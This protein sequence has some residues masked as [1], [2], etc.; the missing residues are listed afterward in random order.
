M[1]ET[2]LHAHPEMATVLKS[3]ANAGGNFVENEELHRT[4]HH[5]KFPSIKGPEGNYDYPSFQ[6][7]GKNA[8][9]FEAILYIVLVYIF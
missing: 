2:S 3:D 7:S 4:L 6:V 8:V 9:E 1:A 5:T